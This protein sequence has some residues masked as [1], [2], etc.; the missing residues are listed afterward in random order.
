LRELCWGDSFWESERVW[1]GGFRGQTSPFTGNSERYLKGGF[2]NGASLSMGALLGEP[3]RGSFVGG[4]EGYERKALGAG[5]SLYGGSL[6]QPEVGS[7]TGTL[8]YG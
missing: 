4:P 6:G 7:S 3:G 5:I 1:E 8:R 2:G